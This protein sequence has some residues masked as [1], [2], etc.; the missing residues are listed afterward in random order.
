MDKQLFLQE[1]NSEGGREEPQRREEAL[2]GRAHARCTTLISTIAVGVLVVVGLVAVVIRQHQT[3]VTSTVYPTINHVPCQSAD[4]SGIHIHAHVTIYING[5]RIPIPAHIGIAAD[6]SCLYWLHTHDASGIIHIEAPVGSSF[7]FGNFLDIWRQQF[8]Q[9]GYPSQFSDPVGWQA[10]V[11]GNVVTSAVQDI[12]L[13][14]HAVITLAYN[15][16]GVIPDTSYPWD[17]L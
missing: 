2:Q 15:S 6:G 12:P 9:L 8:Q 14:S 5:K 7:T 3:P 10:F 16:P 1:A 11:E 13:E 17:G 4:P